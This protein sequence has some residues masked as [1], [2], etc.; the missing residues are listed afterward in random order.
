MNTSYDCCG[1][2][3]KDGSLDRLLVTSMLMLAHSMDLTANVEE[4]SVRLSGMSQC[5]TNMP[6]STKGDGRG[7]YHQPEQ[8]VLKTKRCV[9]DWRR[10]EMEQYRKV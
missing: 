3:H 6:H 1:H 9:N 2:S 10:E 4:N 7:T 5:R 8:Q